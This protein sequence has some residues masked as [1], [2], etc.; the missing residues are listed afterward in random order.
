MT[1]CYELEHPEYG[2]WY[3]TSGYKAAYTIGCTLSY[4]YQRT[5]NSDRIR[6][7][8]IR[9]INDLDDVPYRWIDKSIDEIKKEL[10]I[11]SY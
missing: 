6:H 2:I 9:K 10:S 1:Q 4:F 11:V 8:K 5:K 7:W 3:A